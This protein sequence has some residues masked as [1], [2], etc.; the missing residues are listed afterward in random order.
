MVADSIGESHEKFR[1]WFPDV[2]R[3]CLN[4]SDYYTEEQWSR[5]DMSNGAGSYKCYEVIEKFKF[6][7]AVQEILRKIV[8][9]KADNLAEAEYLV[10][11]AY[12]KERI[13]LSADDL[14]EDNISGERCNIFEA[15][16]CSVEDIPELEVE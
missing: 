14:V 12:D 6:R 16:W 11:E 7:I 2:N 15:D 3:D 8:A 4:C 10:Q 5:R 1:S 13:V 9:V